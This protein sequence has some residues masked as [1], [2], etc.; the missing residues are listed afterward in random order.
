[1]KKLTLLLL[2]ISHIA[3]AQQPAHKKAIIVLTYDD[4]INSQLNIAIPQL[5][6]AYLTATFFLMGNMTEA[7]LPRWREVGKKGYELANH[8]LY[9]PLPAH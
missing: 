2:L 7:T 5:D 6:S 4:G 3:M 8:T 9:H 1:M